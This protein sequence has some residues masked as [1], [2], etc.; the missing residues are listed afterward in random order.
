MPFGV[1]MT[2][3]ME[4]LYGGI[5][6]DLNSRPLVVCECSLSGTLAVFSASKGLLAD[7]ADLR[8]VRHISCN[9]NQSDNV[10]F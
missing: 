6:P 2:V 1:Q 5:P 9:D 3:A 10:N 8:G 4:L 7:R